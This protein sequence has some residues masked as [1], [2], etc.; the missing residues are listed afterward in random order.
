MAFIPQ[1]L[2][3]KFIYSFNAYLWYQLESEYFVYM[4]AYD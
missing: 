1:T 2:R 4:H 3:D